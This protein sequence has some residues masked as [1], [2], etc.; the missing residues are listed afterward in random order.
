M[1][2]GDGTLASGGVENTALPSNNEIRV[3]ARKD[4]SE[5]RYLYY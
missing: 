5:D 4:E 2:D 1:S 3:P